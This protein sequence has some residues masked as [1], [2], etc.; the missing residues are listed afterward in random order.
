MSKK[1]KRKEHRMLTLSPQ[2]L[3]IALCLQTHDV[4]PVAAEKDE[5][6]NFVFALE[7]VADST[8]MPPGTYVVRE[9]QTSYDGPNAYTRMVLA[10][11]EGFIRMDAGTQPQES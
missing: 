4:V 3:G 10:E 11:A 1:Q 9:T 7:P 2:Q 6:G 8:S 5:D